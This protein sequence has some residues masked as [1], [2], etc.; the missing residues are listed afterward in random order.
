MV[1]SSILLQV[2]AQGAGPLSYQWRLNRQAL[3]GAT[4]S[5]F[6]LNDPRAR[7]VAA[8][9]PEGS[10]FAYATSDETLELLDAASETK[11]LSIS[12]TTLWI[13]R[14]AFSADARFLAG[15]GYNRVVVWRT[16]DGA[17]LWEQDRSYL[18]ESIAFSSDS[19]LVAQAA[20]R[21]AIALWRVADGT[22]V[23]TLTGV[24]ANVTALGFSPDKRFL[25]VS[26]AGS[27]VECWRLAD[28]ILLPLRDP[29]SP[30]DLRNVASLA[31]SPD[32]Q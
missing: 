18:P 29:T 10:L 25:T 31:F 24:R 7:E 17:R 9:S 6:E 14:L 5:T 23:R 19:Q 28:G 20:D 15:A 32:N 16:S 13:S 30:T 21:G 27:E 11:R 8:L 12:G 22:L 1:G 4:N 2:S 26:K 3:P